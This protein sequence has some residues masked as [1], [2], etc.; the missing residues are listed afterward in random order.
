MSTVCVRVNVCTCACAC[1]CICLYINMNV[2]E[3]VCACV[4]LRVYLRVAGT[5]GS[6]KSSTSFFASPEPGHDP[7]DGKGS[8][9]DMLRHSA[10]ARHPFAI[11]GSEPEPFSPVTTPTSRVVMDL[12]AQMQFMAAHTGKE[13]RRGVSEP[14]ALAGPSPVQGALWTPEA[15]CPS[16]PPQG[17]QGMLSPADSHANPKLPP[18]R[19]N[20]GAADGRMQEEE[21]EEACEESEATPLLVVCQSDWGGQAQEGVGG[22]KAR[23]WLCVSVAVLLLAAGAMLLSGALGLVQWR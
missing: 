5:G 6:I 13:A 17:C 19:T 21:A 3:C 14:D 15:M 2:C 11:P 20:A 7:R 10:S 9:H 1:T 18:V 8:P 22:G 23:L 16:L 4:Y 12:V